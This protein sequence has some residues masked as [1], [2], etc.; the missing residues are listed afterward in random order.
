MYTQY[1]RPFALFIGGEQTYFSTF[2]SAMS[3][4]IN[5]YIQFGKEMVSK[6]WFWN[7]RVRFGDFVG[8]W[9]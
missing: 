1:N 4:G 8:T 6:V 2:F 9:N 3:Q 5:H 7:G